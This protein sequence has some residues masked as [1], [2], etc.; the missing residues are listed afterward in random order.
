M[1]D[2]PCIVETVKPRRTAA[3][4][5]RQGAGAGL[6]KALWRIVARHKDYVFLGGIDTL[7]GPGM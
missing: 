4:I 1:Y 5:G 3:A 2:I 7:L 6:G